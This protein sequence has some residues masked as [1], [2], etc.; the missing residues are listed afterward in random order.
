MLPPAC[1][2]TGD[3]KF[4]TC[5]F[6]PVAPTIAVTLAELF[7]ELGSMASEPTDAVSVRTVPLAV[8]AVTFAT[9]VNVPEVSAAMSALLQT[10]LPVAPTAVFRQLHPAGA[11][12]D[13]SVVFAGIVATT[14]AL[15]AALG[16]LL[17]TT[18][19]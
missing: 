15:S 18:C 19:V 11:V 4:V 3:A 16:P 17:V 2:G 7:A 9:R 13:A 8:P 1:T 5:R 10:T 12:N 14:V 6:G